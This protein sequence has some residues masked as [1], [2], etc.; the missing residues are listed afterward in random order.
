MLPV[1]YYNILCL[2]I[3]VYFPTHADYILG[4]ALHLRIAGELS[5]PSVLKELRELNL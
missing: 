3:V 2:I 4:P 1:R 5:E